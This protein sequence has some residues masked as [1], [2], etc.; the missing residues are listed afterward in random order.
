MSRLAEKSEI[1]GSD[2]ESRIVLAAGKAAIVDAPQSR[3]PAGRS[4]QRREGG[5]NYKKEGR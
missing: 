4:S 1:L 3:P 5:T 2:R